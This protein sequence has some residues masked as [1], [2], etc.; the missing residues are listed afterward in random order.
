[1]AA[2]RCFASG[3]RILFISAI[4][5]LLPAGASPQDAPKP[6]APGTTASAPG[7]EVLDYDVEWRLI[8]AGTAK[9]TFTSLPR[10]AGAASEVKLH[11]ESAGLVSRLFHVSD[12][13][14]AMLGQNFCAQN[15]F[16]A[17]HEGSRNRETRVVFDALK[18][19]A[20]YVEKDFTKT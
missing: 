7:R 19:S 3:R 18:R 11:L 4:L 1:M 9:L 17:A 14:T 8:P 2:L 10:S 12:D 20:S 5:T 16:L 6:P 15:S 13:Y